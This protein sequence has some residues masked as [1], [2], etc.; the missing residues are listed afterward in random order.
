MFFDVSKNRLEW[1]PPEIESLQSLTDLYLSNNLLIE[2]PDQIGVNLN[3]FF[4][5]SKS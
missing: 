5:N 1:L 2:L 3:P 4:E